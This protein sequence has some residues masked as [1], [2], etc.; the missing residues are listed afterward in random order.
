MRTGAVERHGRVEDAPLTALRPRG[1]ILTRFGVLREVQTTTNRL[2]GLAV[3][4]SG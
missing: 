2:S 3:S 1:A 4:T